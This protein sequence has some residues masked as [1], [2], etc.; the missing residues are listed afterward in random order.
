MGSRGRYR[1]RISSG[2][3]QMKALTAARLMS[4]GTA[5]PAHTSSNSGSAEAEP[6]L[7]LCAGEVVDDVLPPWPPFSCRHMFI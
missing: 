5:S 4:S 2:R 6:L 3:R 1:M 7:L